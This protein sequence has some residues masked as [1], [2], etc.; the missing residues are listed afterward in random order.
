[1]RGCIRK[2]GSGYQITVNLERTLDGKRRQKSKGGFKTKKEAEKVLAQWINELE[3]GDFIELKEKLLKDFF[4][5][6]LNS[7][8][9]KIARNTY[10]FYKGICDNN[11]NP[12]LGNIKLNK[13]KP[14][15][16]DKFITEQLK[17]DDIN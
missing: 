13:L 4:T 15:H 9:N 7:V 16:I 5:E 11:L 3:D 1:M 10:I 17:R 2:H 6:W 14:F 12:A 8:E